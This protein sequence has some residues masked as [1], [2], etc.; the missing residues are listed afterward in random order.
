MSTLGDGGSTASVGGD[1][2]EVLAFPNNAIIGLGRHGFGVIL[3]M[4][5]AASLTGSGGARCAPC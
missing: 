2:L 3:I 1:F 4:I 5:L